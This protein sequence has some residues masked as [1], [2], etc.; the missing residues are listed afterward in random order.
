MEKQLKLFFEFLENDKKL[1]NN[2][3]QSYKRDISQYED[4]INENKLNY[5]K[6]T[7]EDIKK[8][9]ESVPDEK[10][11]EAL[12][13]EQYYLSAILRKQKTIQFLENL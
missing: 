5:A 8:A 4:Y 7:D 13:K 1:S 3:L 6:V 11:K 9:L 2:T 10:E 12:K